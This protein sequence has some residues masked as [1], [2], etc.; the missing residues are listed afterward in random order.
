MCGSR[1]VC[2]YT[3]EN[4]KVK[5]WT[6]QAVNLSPF[7]YNCIFLRVMLDLGRGNISPLAAHRTLC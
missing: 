3:N 4:S 1:D 5:E 6:V 2:G 7:I